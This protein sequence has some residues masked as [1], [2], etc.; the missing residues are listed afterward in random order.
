VGAYVRADVPTCDP[1]DRLQD[2]RERLGGGWETC[3]VV[4]GE[5]VVLGQL[6]RRALARE[7]DVSAEEAM[8]SGPS[9][10]RPSARLAAIVERMSKQNLTSLIVT[11]SDGRLV[12]LLERGRAEEALAQRGSRNG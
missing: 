11:T 8:R 4:N 3:L 12:G 7:D 9:T 1:G 5:R 10:V 2:V 6:G